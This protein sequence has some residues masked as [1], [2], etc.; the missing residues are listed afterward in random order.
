MSSIS[1]KRSR[2]WCFTINNYTELGSI[3]DELWTQL[4][5]DVHCVYCIFGFE[6]APSTG[7]PHIQGYA[8]WQTLKSGKQ[9][10]VIF[11]GTKAHIEPAGGTPAQNRIYCVKSGKF[12]EHGDVPGSGQ[13][14]RNDLEDTRVLVKQ[15]GSLRKVIESGCNYQ[16]VKY[17]I[18]ILPYIERIRDWKPQVLWFWGPTG[19]GKTKAAFDI[20]SAPEH[21]YRN[22]GNMKWWDGYDGQQNVIIDDIRCDSIP[23][24]E[25]LALLD[26]YEYRVEIK[27]GYRQFLA[28]RMII[29]CP[30]DPA[31][32][33]WGKDECVRQLLRRIDNIVQFPHGYAEYMAPCD[34]PG[35]DSTNGTN[36]NESTFDD[37]FCEDYNKKYDMERQVSDSTT[38]ILS[39][40]SDVK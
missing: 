20:F 31:T 3:I 28:K 16:N 29:T 14:K 13:G 39:S 24:P 2:G 18:T 23:F 37:S 10:L 34:G 1:Q 6:E 12:K 36:H 7:T 4:T 27:G 26:R 8:Y 21:R 25:L 15:T 40:S 33:Y 11:D 9:I 30:F 22:N 5:D 32:M 38:V 19:T 17:A 35:D